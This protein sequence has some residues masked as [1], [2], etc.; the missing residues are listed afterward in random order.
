MNLEE[1]KQKIK[2]FNIELTDI[3]EQ[4]LLIYKEFLI[5]YNSHTNLTRITNEEDIYLKHFYDSITILKANDLK[6][7]NNLLDIG[8]GAGFPGMIIKIL[9]PE[10]EVTLLD[11]NNKKTKFLQ[12]LSKKLN[13]DKINITHQRAEEFASTNKE[14]FDIVTSR[15]VANIITLSELSIPLLKI[16]GYFIALKGDLTKEADYTFALSILGGK[17]VKNIEFKL[18]IENSQRNILVIKKTKK[19]PSEYPRLYDKIIKYPLLN[20]KK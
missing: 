17:L 9:F 19:T 6:T 3:Q 18:P 12:E 1:F 4:Q 13:I 14:K 16:D 11:S 8:T 2:E 15:A 10:I 5:E 20:S 7:V